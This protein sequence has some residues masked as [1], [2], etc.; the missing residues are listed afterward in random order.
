GP[1]RVG[2]AI[3]AGGGNTPGARPFPFQ[4]RSFALSSLV[5]LAVGP[6]LSAGLDTGPLLLRAEA[7]M[8]FQFTQAFTSQRG[9]PAAP[10]PMGAP[11][12]L[13]F[14]MGSSGPPP[15]GL[16]LNDSRFRLAPRIS[17]ELW[18]GDHWT[19]G[20]AGSLDVIYRDDFGLSCFLRWY[21]DVKGI[22]DPR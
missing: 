11:R 2:P 18:L 8:G 4:G 6:N 21:A 5:Y 14:P 13:W 12:A 22:H 7:F 16:V 19:L 10:P 15:D 20:V 3:E 17:A 9:G 1:I